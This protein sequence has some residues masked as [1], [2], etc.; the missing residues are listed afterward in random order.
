MR[1]GTTLK[2]ERS[3]NFGARDRI[4]LSRVSD[5]RRG[6]KFV[7]GFNGLLKFVPTSNYNSYINLHNLQFITARKELFQTVVASPVFAR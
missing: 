1:N 7:T 2:N 3:V 5:Y 4:P 6:L